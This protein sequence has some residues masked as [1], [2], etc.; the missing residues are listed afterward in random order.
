MSDM[1]ITP[2]ASRPTR[3]EPVSQTL[4]KSVPVEHQ[5]DQPE[6]HPNEE[7]RKNQRRKGRAYRRP[8]IEL[9]T[10][11]DRRRGQHAVDTDV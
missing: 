7:R 11:D 10:G 5:V 1:R 2:I 8:L 3:V 4:P 6:S 9:R